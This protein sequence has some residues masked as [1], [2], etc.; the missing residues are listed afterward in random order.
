MV[1]YHDKRI[2]QPGRKRVEAEEV[3]DYIRGQKNEKERKRKIP[4]F[5]ILI[6]LIFCVLL[7]VAHQTRNQKL[8]RAE[9]SDRKKFPK[10]TITVCN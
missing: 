2:L 9:P 8:F 10:V 1:E 6:F 5:R 3:I 4:K 7:A